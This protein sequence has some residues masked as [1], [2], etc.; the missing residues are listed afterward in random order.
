MSRWL[1]GVLAALAIGCG[2][3]DEEACK[4]ANEVADQIRDQA[5]LDGITGPPCVEG[6]ELPDPARAAD[7]KRAC[8]RY[9]ELKEK[10]DG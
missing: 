9:R 4:E 7:Y 2:G 5:A 10:C 8:D 6:P 1:A 3:G